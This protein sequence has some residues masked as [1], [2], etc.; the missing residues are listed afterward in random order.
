MALFPRCNERLKKCVE[1]WKS[2]VQ[3]LTTLGGVDLQYMI[4]PVGLLLGVFAAA[5]RFWL[6]GM[7]ESRKK[8]MNENKELLIEIQQ[9]SSLTTLNREH[10]LSRIA[11]QEDEERIHSFLAVGAGGLLDGLYLYMGVTSL[12]ILSP[13][14]FLAM[15]IFSVFYT[16]AC[17][18]TRIY[19]EYDFQMRLMITQTK[20]KLALTSKEMEIT[21]SKLLSLEEKTDKTPEDIREIKRLKL[22]V[23]E[24]IKNFEA[25][26]QL[27]KEQSTR[28]YL[29]AG[30]LGMKYGLYAYGVLTS[31]LFMVTSVFLVTA[32]AFPPALLAAF[33]VTGIVLMAGFV[34]YTLRAHYLH[35]QKQKDAHEE[36][37]MCS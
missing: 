6:R 33:I 1:G 27:L 30:L 20:C 11:Y 22:E 28:S 3:L 26:R 7:L 17:V 5:N 36:H 21:Y 9:L 4:I 2:T 25:L 13:P 19:E 35:M 24:L 12:S 8:K 14:L 34:A 18:I 32:T 23:C 16:L 15:S 31:L 10:Y 37:S 29:T